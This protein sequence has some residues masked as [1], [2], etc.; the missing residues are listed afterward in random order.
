MSVF[1]DSERLRTAVASI[2]GQ[3]WRDLELIVIDDGSTDGSGELL[4]ELAAADVRLRVIHQDN[5]GLTRAL[6]RGCS[7]TRGEFIARQ[8]SDDWSHPQRIAE[9]VALL[10]GDPGIGFVSCATQYLGPADEPLCV[11][12]RT[13][14]S[15]QA[16]EGLLHRREGPPAHGSVMF[17]STLYREVGGY[18]GQFR[19]SQDSDLW[20][21]MGERARIGY[22]PGIRYAHRK[23][24]ASTSGAARPAQRRFGELGHLCRK[25]RLAGQSEQPWLDEAETLSA[26]VR[27]G[28]A[29]DPRARRRA[30]ADANYLLGSILTASKNTRAQI[31]LLEAIRLIPLRPKPWIRLV[32][33]GLTGRKVPAFD[34]E[35]AR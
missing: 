30:M 13:T 27:D 32:Q 25:S 26:R 3:T 14:D 6:I 33:S 17:R 8:D 28:V 34:F 7:E 9:Q 24:A 19:Y 21:R 4:D 15:V 20:L 22:V 5:T 23:D 12:S 16:T 10:D 29:Q 31:Y 2:L 18:R 35:D 11:I 1:N